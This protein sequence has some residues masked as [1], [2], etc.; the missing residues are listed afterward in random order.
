MEQQLSRLA[1]WRKFITLSDER[2][3]FSNDEV[4]GEF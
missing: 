3:L 4:E 1:S 2:Q